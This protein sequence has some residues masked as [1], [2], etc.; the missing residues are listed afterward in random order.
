MVCVRVRVEDKFIGDYTVV[1]CYK[2]NNTWIVGEIV[3]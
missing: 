3:C 1:I 2:I